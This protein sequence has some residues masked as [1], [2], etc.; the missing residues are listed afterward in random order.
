LCSWK[1]PTG[2]R[3]FCLVFKVLATETVFSSKKDVRL[4]EKVQRRAT[5][6]ER[7]I[8]NCC[9]EDRLAVL[10]LTFIMARPQ[11]QQRANAITSKAVKEWSALLLW[12]STRYPSINSKFVRRPLSRV[13][14]FL[15]HKQWKHGNKYFFSS[16]INNL[17]N[18][19]QRCVIVKG[20][21]TIGQLIGR[22]I[23][24]FQS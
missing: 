23:D 10:G 3:R 4:L 1:V 20:A 15:L 8:T 17:F 13:T 19:K 12:S 9:Y 2:I 18:S 16:K 14:E 5:K 22:S 24:Q 21:I 11:R 7:R 6:L